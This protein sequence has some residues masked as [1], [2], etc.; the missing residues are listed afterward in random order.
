MYLPCCNKSKSIYLSNSITNKQNKTFFKFDIVS[1]Y[2][3]I[4]AKLLRDAI[5]WAKSVITISDSDMKLIFHC[6]KMFLFL[7]DDV[8]VKKDNPDFDVSMGGL[9]SA[10]V[11]ELVGLYIL[12]QMERLIPPEDLGLY[13]D[14][15][16]GV[17][18][19]PGPEIER[20]RKK[21]VKLFSDH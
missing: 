10:E 13:R 5:S 9:D 12:S 8:W 14:D 16:L 15:G 11:C 20:L 21:V 17:V 4:T 3:S 1:F 7:E 6:R 2:P 19:L 18:D